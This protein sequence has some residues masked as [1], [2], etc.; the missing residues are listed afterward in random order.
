M[1]QRFVI[2]SVFD[3]ASEAFSPLY[4]FVSRGAAI[5]SFQQEMK[6][7]EGHMAKSPADYALFHVADFEDSTGTVVPVE[8]E[9][10]MR[11]Q[12]VQVQ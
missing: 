8:K 12:D 7:P 2:V 11:G 1:A 10:L 6:N 9:R 3:S 4:T 5:R